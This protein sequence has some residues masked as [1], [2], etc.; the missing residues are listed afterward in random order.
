MSA[1]ISSRES[2]PGAIL[3]LTPI[4]GMPPDKSSARRRRAS[5]GALT[6]PKL[7]GDSSDDQV[8]SVTQSRCVV[9]AE[10]KGH[11]H[12]VT[13]TE[14]ALSLGDLCMAIRT[15]QREFRDLQG[16]RTA[17]TLRI[18]ARERSYAVARNLAAGGLGV[19]SLKNGKFKFPEVTDADSAS[20]KANMPRLHEARAAI[21]KT[22]KE[23]Q[24]HRDA[25][26]A[27][28]PVAKLAC[29]VPG[30]NVGCVAAIV[31]EAGDLFSYSGPAKLWKRMGLD[32]R[33]DGT[34]P[35]LEKGKRGTYNPRRRA[36]MRVIAISMR[37]AR[38]DSEYKSIYRERKEY[39]IAR[40]GTTGLKIVSGK[41]KPGT[42][43]KMHIDNRALRFMEKRFLRDLWHAW[44]REAMTDLSPAVRVPLAPKRAGGGA[45]AA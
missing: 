35:R 18:K 39:E 37:M 40:S 22:L 25:I 36:E 27:L 14:G 34:A 42:I 19:V 10:R 41:E 30:I 13:R 29:A 11:E 33:S 2:G 1:H 5:N 9:G 15:R 17:L 45:R 7:R 32:V 28:L 23:C 20:V 3:G 43:S 31:C 24:S 44:R 12:P 26:V 8:S 21:D 4:V 38:G 16:V 6:T